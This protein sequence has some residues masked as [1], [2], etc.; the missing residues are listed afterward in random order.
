[1]IEVAI[2]LGASVHS[3]PDLI[4]PG[5]EIIVELP[6]TTTV[7]P[8]TAKHQFLDIISLLEVRNIL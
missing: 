4:F 7:P 1:M 2:K 6:H 8:V 3:T 5:R